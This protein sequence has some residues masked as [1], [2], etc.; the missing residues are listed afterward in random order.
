MDSAHWSSLERPTATVR[1]LPNSASPLPELGPFWSDRN[2]PVV[3]GPAAPE[4]RRIRFE[5]MFCGRDICSGQKRGRLVGKT[6]R[7]KGTKIMGI[8]D[9][10]GLPLALRTESASPAEVKLVEPTMQERLVPDVPERL[11]GDK[12]YDSDRLD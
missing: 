4:G 6:K 11:I 10:H 9:S 12:A 2:H 7:G 3:A 5:R 8:A 1:F